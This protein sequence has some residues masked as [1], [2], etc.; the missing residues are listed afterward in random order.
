MWFCDLRQTPSLRECACEL[1]ASVLRGLRG[2][3][4]TCWPAVR[5]ARLGRYTTLPFRRRC[6]A[7]AP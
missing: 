1:A 5:S 6:P 2:R 7:A 3:L 4:R